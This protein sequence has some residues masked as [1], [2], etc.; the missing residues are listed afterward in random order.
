MT[1]TAEER[2]EWLKKLGEVAA[3]SD[4]FYPFSDNVYRLARSGVKYA[5][6]PT[7]SV[8]DSVSSITIV[9][10][11]SKLIYARPC[12]RQPRFRG[13]FSSSST[14]VY[15]TTSVVSRTLC[16]T[17]ALRSANWRAG[18]LSMSFYQI[19]LGHQLPGKSKSG[20][21]GLNNKKTPY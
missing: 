6:A 16:L 1:F 13:L 12:L 8:N 19:L 21:G 9:Y 17:Y 7:G 5:A 18:F 20:V 3:S 4:A 11:V 2:E 10:C 14:Y 15:S